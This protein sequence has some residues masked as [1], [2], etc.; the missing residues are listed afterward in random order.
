MGREYRDYQERRKE[1]EY[2]ETKDYSDDK[3]SLKI[4]KY[5]IPIIWIFGIAGILLVISTLYDDQKSIIGTIGFSSIL[6]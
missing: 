2:I 4:D 6:V 5:L 1:K 3:N